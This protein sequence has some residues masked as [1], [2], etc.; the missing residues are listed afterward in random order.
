M[1]KVA[2]EPAEPSMA[3]LVRSIVDQSQ[4]F[5]RAELDLIKVEARQNATRAIIAL[6]VALICSSLL[7]FTL[8]LGA[9]A[10]VLTR[11]GS[12]TAALWTAAGVD[13]G[14]VLLSLVVTFVMLRKRSTAQRPT[15]S[16][17]NAPQHGTQ[18][19]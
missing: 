4:V 7:A 15:S 2:L 9:A 6:V 18:V 5:V 3:E 13:F 12:P 11:H 16:L 8:S 19:T 1:S 17:A 14:A 10:L